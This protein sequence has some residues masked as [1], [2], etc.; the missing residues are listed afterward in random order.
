[1]GDMVHRLLER[2]VIINEQLVYVSPRF[3]F[4][5]RYSKNI[6]HAVDAHLKKL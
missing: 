3:N 1:M 2:Y 6:C 5:G 4:A